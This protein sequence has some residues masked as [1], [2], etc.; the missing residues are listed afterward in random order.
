VEALVEDLVEEVVGAVVVAV[1]DQVEDH[2]TTVASQD[3]CRE[4]AQRSVPL[5]RLDRAVAVEAEGLAIS[6]V[7]RDICLATVQRRE[8]DHLVVQMIEN[9][10]IVERGDIYQEIVLKLLPSDLEAE[11]ANALH[12]AQRI[13]SSETVPRRQREVRVE[14]RTCAVTTATRWD[15]CLATV[16]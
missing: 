9:V 1:E 8:I 7:R 11:E 15:T 2:A 3:I 10:T 14:Q 16:P 13:I 12:V 4:T 5:G 6:A